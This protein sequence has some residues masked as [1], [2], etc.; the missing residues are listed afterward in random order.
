M[1]QVKINNQEFEIPFDPMQIKLDEYIAY[2]DQYGRKIE[3]QLKDFQETEWENEEDKVIAYDDYIDN[4]AIAWFSFWTKIP[5]KNA[6][7]TPDILPIL[8][9]YRIMRSL[10]WDAQKEAEDRYTEPIN[11]L[12]EKWVIQDFKVNAVSKMNFNEVTTSKEVMRQVVKFESGKW[13]ALKYLS[14]IFLRKENEPFTD[15]L[16]LEDSERLRLMGEL[17][18]G[19]AMRVGFFLSSCVSSLSRI[20]AFS[21][22]T[23]ILQNQN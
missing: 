19:Y 2:Y 3:E 21:Q 17:P 10:F 13:V 11:W 6:K 4:E 16:I 5:L 9:H 7:N 15:E 18:V 1:S 8:E 12:G 20:L 22:G 14:N 23:G